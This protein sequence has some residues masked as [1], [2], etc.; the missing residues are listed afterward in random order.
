[1]NLFDYQWTGVV[2]DTKDPLKTGRCRVRIFGV[3]SENLLEVPTSHLPW[4]I[5]TNAPNGMHSFSTPLEGDLVIGVFGDG[6]SAQM[7]IITHVIPG[8]IK[9]GFDSS[10]GFS[11]Q[12][13]DPIKRDLPQGQIGPGVGRSTTSQLAKGIVAGTGIQYT[14]LNLDRACDFRFQAQFDLGLGSLVNPQAALQQ[15]IKNGKNRAA[16][17]IRLIVTKLQEE[18]RIVVLGLLTALGVDPSGQLSLEYSIAKNIFRE[19]NELT[20]KVAQYV[21]DISFVVSLVEEVQQIVEYLNSLPDRF[22]QLVQDCILRF[23]ESVESVSKQLKSIPGQVSDN[24]TGALGQLSSSLQT[25]LSS[26][27]TSASTMSLS[28]AISTIL[29]DPQANVA[30][31]AVNY[32]STSYPSAET[33]VAQNSENSFNPETMTAP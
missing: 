19:V 33:V 18:L 5:C 30:G 15:A 8:F 6:K 2:E 14:N 3:H 1:M 17:A 31:V 20:K 7:P 21:S 23:T 25:N 22:K 27:T 13:K 4:A 26:Q 11:P 10:K 16:V 28:P 9:K 32:I 12:S 24:L 29:T